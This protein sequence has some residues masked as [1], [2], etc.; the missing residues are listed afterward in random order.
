MA[1]CF[2]LPWLL[3][4]MVNASPAPIP[5]PEPVVPA[6]IVDYLSA[7][8]Q[9]SYFLRHLQR[10]GLIPLIN[11]LQNVTVF[12]PVNLAFVDGDLAAHDT[13]ESLMRYFGGQVLS[14]E[15][16]SAHGDIVDSLYVTKRFHGYNTS[17]PLKVTPRGENAMCV[18][19]FAGV[20]E[21]D[22]YAKHQYSTIQT[23][24]RLLPVPET[25]CS[26]LMDS[27]SAL[28]N[29]YSVSFI[30][31]L[32]QLVFTDFRHSG[33][34]ISCEE[35]LANA[36]TLFLPTDAL[37]DASMLPLQKKY[38]TTLFT[39]L[40]TPELVATK[41]AV[42]EIRADVLQLLLNLLLPSRIGGC[43]AENSTET[44][45]SG[46]VSYNVSVD[47]ESNRLILN[48]SVLSA[49]NSTS[50][51]A[52]DGLIHVFDLDQTSPQ[53]FFGSMGI[54]VADIIPRKAL[55]ALH[56]SHFVRELKFRKLDYLVDGSTT[57][58]TI[59]LESDNR[60]DFS[61]EDLFVGLDGDDGEADASSF[62][63]KQ[64]LLYHFF[65]GAIDLFDLLTE[66]SP[67]YHHLLTSKLCLHKRI[68]SCYRAKLSGAISNEKKKIILFND[69]VKIVD[70]PIHA[71]GD[72]VI[73]I[74]DDELLAPASFKH[75]VGELISND[76]VKGGL[77]H[78]VIDKES[79]LTT[80]KY[81]IK[82]DL[83]SLPNNVNGYSVFLPCGNPVWDG[84][85]QSTI[86]D[87]GSWKSLGLVIKYL[88]SNTDVLKN[89]LKGLFIQDLVYSDFGLQDETELSILAQTL[90]GDYVNVSER[91]RSGEFNHLININQTSF[92]VPL[93]SDV[94]FSHGVI[95]ITSKLL[96]P[97]S[98]H[99]LLLDLAKTTEHLLYP[100][101]SFLVLLD[102]FPKV[103][104][105]LNL[106]E[107]HEDSQYSLLIPSPDL[108]KDFNVTQGYSR[109]YEFLELHLVPNT[110]VDTLLQCLNDGSLKGGYRSSSNYSIHT[111]SSK[112]AFNCF[113][114]KATGETYIYLEN[115]DM[116]PKHK[117]RIMSHG[118]T[119]FGSK[120]SSC[121]FLLDGPLKP[122]W[123][124]APPS[125]FLHLHIGWISV[126]IGI[127]I[128]VVLFGFFTT[129]V[130]L[131]LGGGAA[132]K[133]SGPLFADESFS[134]PNE[135]TFMR[136]TSDED[137]IEDFGY[138][139][140]DDM[141]RSERDPILAKGKKKKK[142]SN[143]SS[144]S[145]PING[146]P[147]APRT[148]K[149]NRL[150]KGLSRDRDFP[151]I[152]F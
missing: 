90:R 2:W 47:S 82:F 136:V 140:D 65:E 81:L 86:E 56:Y 130:I 95:H 42:R 37:V 18:N 92:S 61:D 59:L 148:I 57:N 32:A 138:E 36:S 135:P 85:Q 15:S 122:E 14:M 64:S 11:R 49:R 17:F 112:G 79:C 71:S 105:A 102:L 115:Y 133:S 44:T 7:S 39:G 88:E 143:Y 137:F 97:D 19:D 83:L 75:T 28:V 40:I 107:T 127:I 23:I 131:C 5:S 48:G 101:H 150:L 119:Q 117:V 55:F 3:W 1:L 29:G 124:D 58:Q 94:L 34:S 46:S 9:Y 116:N 111:N 63:G 145:S 60:D 151:V 113:K 93:N 108:L 26:V 128:G 139:T 114:N 98:F 87:S 141:M 6:T 132:K 91:Y 68:N 52:A 62:S 110:E 104:D 89:I 100:D 41:D 20:V 43:S 152:N 142:F 146:V 70:K 67:F 129:T 123:F 80:L 99:V 134:P 69:D 10:H 121:V 25:L 54:S 144:T 51:V 50:I 53:D 12:A 77:D 125:N 147:S 76:V 74:T 24:D 45:L 78:I 106:E 31:H 22:G 96:L 72:N 27:N 35:Y 118:C 84:D 13:P 120:N 21:W 4:A 16:F 103:K 33:F 30:K 66:N 109:L 8:A 149:G 73:Y 126:G 38:Y